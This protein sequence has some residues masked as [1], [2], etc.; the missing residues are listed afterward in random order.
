M[1]RLSEWRDPRGS[2]LPISEYRLL[3]ALGRGEQEA[4]EIAEVIREQRQLNYAV[5]T[6]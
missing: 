6:I 5:S 3:L 1:N 4:R 2:S